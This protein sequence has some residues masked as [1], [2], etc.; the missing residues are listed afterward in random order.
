MGGA[1][2][3]GGAT[4][5][6]AEKAGLS[7]VWAGAATGGLALAGSALLPNPQLKD[8]FFAAGLGGMGVAGVQLLGGLYA[9][10]KQQAA[11][12]SRPA[13]A[14]P[15]PRR[16]AEGDDLPAPYITRSE[17]NAALS[18]LADKN[19][20]QHKQTC[21]LMTAL[22]GEIRKVM[23]EIQPSQAK[24]AA[25]Q[26]P[27]LYPLTPAPQPATRGA[28]VDDDRNSDGDDYERNAYGE[29]DERNADVDER[30]SDGDD[31]ER[32]AYADDERDADVD[33][34]RNAYGDD[35][36]RNAD[37]DELM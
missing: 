3:G 24:P 22:H 14:S 20:D 33:D 5:L 32:N 27:Y 16:Q 31:Y 8:A 34:E 29:E 35:D 26:P 6:V 4:L 36:E 10:Q 12:A 23:T 7:P 18:Q 28:Y 13:A 30:D 11:A 37:G 17:L 15:A 9:K 19:D 1:I 21:D 25:T 2:A